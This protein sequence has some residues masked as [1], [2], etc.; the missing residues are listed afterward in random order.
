V[1]VHRSAPGA[2]AVLA[3]LPDA[4]SAVTAPDLAL[5]DLGAVGPLG[6]PSRPPEVVVLLGH[7]LAALVGAAASAAALRR[8]VHRDGA[9]DAPGGDGARG[10]H[11]GRALLRSAVMTA[12]P[13]ALRLRRSRDDHG[14]V[15]VALSVI[16]AAVAGAALAAVTAVGIT[17]AGSAKPAD[18]KEPLATYDTR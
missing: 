1:F 6:S 10:H 4:R 11:R 7:G 2:D 13:S 14:A 18:V 16:A 17:A 15:S 9:R 3:R 12:T 5:L 8:P